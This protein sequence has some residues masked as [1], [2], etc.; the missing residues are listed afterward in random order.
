MKKTK[1]SF[2]DVLIIGGG[3]AGFFAAINTKLHYP[4]KTVAILEKTNKVLSKVKI[5]GGGRCNVTHACSNISEMIKAYPRGKNFLKK[6]FHQFFTHDLIEWFALRNIRLKTENDGRMFPV[7]DSSQT[8]IDCFLQ[9]CEKLAIPILLQKDIHIINKKSGIFEI[10][11]KENEVFNSEFLI[12]CSGGYPNQSNYSWIKNIGKEIEEP[13][14]SL[15]TFNLPKHPITKLMGLSVENV[16]VEIPIAKLKQEG[17]VLITHW[18]MSGP[19]ILKS[20]AWGAKKLKECN[21]KFDYIINFLPDFHPDKLGN[22]FMQ[23]K[24]NWS[25]KSMQSKMFK[26]IPQRLWNYFLQEANLLEKNW[27]DANKKQLFH[28]ARLLTKNVFSANGKTTFKEEFVTAGGIITSEVNP[29][30]LESNTIKNLYFAGECLNI[31]GIT[32]GFNFQAAWTT[33]FIASKLGKK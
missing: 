12:L 3:A 5:S 15:F 18:G 30:S 33:A 10:N 7:T 2:Y 24:E 11:T 22:Y 20:S 9:E 31:D 29:H 16:I 19:A 4:E 25:K 32:G 21:Y 17:P 27:A 26:E 8:I 6:S 13:Y 23:E 14:P 1:N 28:L